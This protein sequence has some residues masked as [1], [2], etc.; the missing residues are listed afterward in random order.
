M[1]W[2]SEGST[3]DGRL[4]DIDTASSRVLWWGS[5]PTLDGLIASARDWASGIDPDLECHRLLLLV[6]GASVMWTCMGIWANPGERI[7]LATLWD[8]DVDEFTEDDLELVYP[9]GTHD[10]AIVEDV[11][12]RVSELPERRRVH[13][14][15][16]DGTLVWE[17]GE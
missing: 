5:E 6:D 13:A 2:M 17:D 16:I 7:V 11:M 10:R 8:A 3:V 15:H 4:V 9:Q 14:I 12:R 1:S